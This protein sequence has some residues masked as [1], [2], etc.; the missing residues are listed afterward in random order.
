MQRKRGCFGDNWSFYSFCF[1]FNRH[2]PKEKTKQ[3]SE[4]GSFFYNVG[5]FQS[6]LL[7]IWK[8]YETMSPRGLA[9]LREAVSLNGW[10]QLEESLS[11]P[12]FSLTPPGGAPSNPGC[13]EVEQQG[14]LISLPSQ[15]R[16]SL[17]PP[18]NATCPH[19][20]GP[21]TLWETPENTSQE[22]QSI[23]FLRTLTLAQIPNSN[24]FRMKRNLYAKFSAWE[25]LTTL[26]TYIF[27][28][29]NLWAKGGRCKMKARV[30]SP[31]DM[32]DYIRHLL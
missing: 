22:A 3:N 30:A 12:G 16:P 21:A 5:F 18:V 32:L 8:L 15:Q 4:T 9:V 25:L 6:L 1:V 19:L 23:A 11:S 2:I 26:Y 28:L 13:W 17:Q 31:R 7:K 20:T 14:P 24:S 29:V 10:P 27:L